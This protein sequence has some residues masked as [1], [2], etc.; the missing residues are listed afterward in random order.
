MDVVFARK[1]WL[2][3]QHLR[4][5]TTRAP[6]INLYIVFLPC[7]HDLWGSVVSRRDIAG[8]LRVLEAGKT[9]IADLQVT[10]FVDQD[11]ARLQVAMNNTRRVDIFQATLQD[12]ISACSVRAC[13]VAGLPEFDRESIV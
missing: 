2:A 1:Q 12:P 8:H 9:E 7:E 13:E 10:V 5:D 6:D 4:K 11:I 3:F